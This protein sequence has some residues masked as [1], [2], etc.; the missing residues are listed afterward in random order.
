MVCYDFSNQKAKI[1][2][3]YNKFVIETMNNN[4]INTIDLSAEYVKVKNLLIE[5]DI[6]NEQLY[7]LDASM[8][9]I[10]NKRYGDDQS[11]CNVNI[12]CDLSLAGTFYGPE[13][14]IIEPASHGDNSGTVV[15]RGNLQVQGEHTFINSQTIEVSDNIIRMHANYNSLDFGGIEVV[16]DTG[17][18]RQFLWN[19]IEDRWILEDPLFLN[20]DLDVSNNVNISGDLVVDGNF[21]LSG[22][23]DVDND[24]SFNGN[25]D[26]SNHLTVEGDASFNG[27]V[28]ISGILKADNISLGEILKGLGRFLLI[29]A[30]GNIVD[31]SFISFDGSSVI[32]D[33]SAGLKIPAGTTDE[34]PVHALQGHI[35]YNNTLDSFEGYDGNNWGKLGGLKDV[36]GDTYISVETSAGNDNDDLDFYTAG[37]RYLQIDKGGNIL[38]GK[39]NNL[40]KFTISGETGDTKIAGTVEISGNEGGV[41]LIVHNDISTNNIYMNQFIYGNEIMYIDPVH[42]TADNSGLLVIRADVQILGTQTTINS[43]T[44]EVSHNIIVHIPAALTD[45]GLKVKDQNDHLRPFVFKNAPDFRWDLSDAIIFRDDA[46]FSNNVDIS[47]NLYVNGDVSFQRN[48]DVSGRLTT[49]TFTVLGDVSFN[50]NV[51]ISD[52]LVTYGDVSLISAVDISGKL[53]IFD[54]GTFLGNG[55]GLVVVNDASLNNDLYL[56]GTLYTGQNFIIDPKGHGDNTGL[57]IIKGGLQVDGSSTVINSTVLDISDHRILLSSNSTNQSQTDGAGIE[58]SNNKL[59]IY[60]YANDRWLT[61]IGLNVSGD[62]IVNEDTSLNN[63]VDISGKFNINGDSSFNK[64]VD[65]NNNFNVYSD[66]SFNGN[67]YIAQH[68]N[69]NDTLSVNEDASFNQNVIINETLEVDGIVTLNNN[70]DISENLYVNGDV[71]F[72]RNLDVSGTIRATTIKVLGDVSFDGFV[73]ISD[74]LVVYG[75]ASFNQDVDICGILHGND[76]IINGDAS[77]NQNVEISDQL[78]V[79]GDVS[80]NSFVDISDRLVVNGDASFNQDVDIC[81]ILH[82]NKL[83]I[84]GD[85]SFNNNVDISENLY[86]NGDVSFQRNLDVSGQ[87]IATTIKILGDVSFNVNVDVSDRLVVYGDVSLN[88]NVDVSDRLV[89]EGDVSLNENV[90]ISNQLNVNGDASFNSNVDISNR[91]NVD[92]IAFHGL[93][94]DLNV[95][96]NENS[97][98]VAGGTSTSK[99]A[100]SQD[101]GNNWTEIT[102]TSTLFTN[103]A[104]GAQS[105]EFNGSMWVAA[106]RGGNHVAYSYDGINW[107]SGGTVFSHNG[108]DIKYDN[109]RGRWI[110]VGQGNSSTI[111]YSYDGINWTTLAVN[112]IEQ[113]IMA[114]DLN[115][116]T[117]VV[118][119]ETTAGAPTLAHSYDLINWTTVGVNPFERGRCVLWTGERWLAGGVIGDRDYSIVYSEDGT[120]WNDIANADNLAQG[121]SNIFSTSC[122]KIATNGSTI[123]AVGQGTNTIAYS[124][125]GGLTFTGLGTSI[126]GSGFSVAWC[127]IQWVVGGNNSEMAVSRDGIVWTPVTSPFTSTTFDIAWNRSIYNSLVDINERL[128]TMETKI[129]VSYR[130]VDISLNL[131]V[132]GDASFNQNVDISGTLKVTD[133]QVLGDASFNNNVD[134]SENLY[135]N[136]DVF[137]QR[138]LDVSDNLYVNGDVSFQR[139]LDV[140]GKL[141]VT[142]LEVLGDVSFNGN[143]D[144]SNRLLV[145]GDVSFQSDVD[146]SK[147]L[148]V[149]GETILS[150]LRVNDLSNNRVVIVGPSG[151]LEDDGNF[152]FDG[153]NLVIDTSHA[154]QIPVGTTGERPDAVTGQIRFNVTDNRYEGYNG[155][156]WVP[157]GESG[158][159]LIVATGSGT[160][161]LN[162]SNDHGETWNPVTDSTTLF[163]QAEDVAWNGRRWVAVGEGPSNIAYSDDG[164]IWFDATNSSSLFSAQADAIGANNYLWV[165]GGSFQP[166]NIIYSSDGINW[167]Y[168]NNSPFGLTCNDVKYGGNLW[169]AA[170]GYGVTSPNYTLGYSYNGKDWYGGAGAEIFATQGRA[171]AWN[172]KLWVAVGG[173]VSTPFIIAYSYDGKN[174]N[175]VT[176]STSIIKEAYGIAWNGS[177]FVIVGESNTTLGITNTIL[178]SEDGINWTGRGTTVFG[179]GVTI[180]RARGITWTGSNWIAVGLNQGSPSNTIATSLDGITWVGKGS[181]NFTTRGTGVA[182]NNVFDYNKYQ[183]ETLDISYRNVD[184]SLN[185]LVEGRV[186]ISGYVSLNYNVDISENLYVNG[187]VSFQRNL[188]VS[189]TIRATTIKVLGDV[190]FDGFVDISDRLVVYGD[191]SFNQDVDICGIL[192]G[193]DLIINGDASF[194]QNVDISGQLIVKGDVSLNSNVDISENLYV[195]GDVSF[196]RN[197]DVSGQLT[198]T[199]L[200]V[201]GDVS[202]DGFV[203]ISNRLVAYSDASF[204]QDVDICGI[205]HGN[206][207]IINSD[208]SFNNNVTISNELIVNSDVSLNSNVDISENL[209]VNGDVSFQ[210]N[211]DV[212]GLLTVTTLKVLGDVSF[213]GNVDISDRL[214]AYGDASF[215]ED[216]DICGTLHGYKLIINDDAS[217]NSIVDIS[218]QLIVNGDVSLNSNVDISENLYVNGDVSFQRNLDVSGQIVATSLKVLGD[219]SFNRN[220]DISD[221]LVVYVDTSLNGN[222]DIS[223]RLV[224]YGDVSL[225]G[226]VDISDKLVVRGDASFNSN[227]NVSG[228]TIL[229]TLRVNDL[230]ET[231]IVFVGSSGELIDSSFLTFDGSNLIIDTSYSIQIPVGTTDERPNPAE[232]GQIRYNITDSTFEGYDGNNWGSLGGVKDVD[233]DTYIL[234]ES[235]PGAD[236]DELQFYSAG[237][238]Y[239][240]IDGYGNII[241]GSNM[242]TISGETGKT[243]IAGDVS[244][245]N[246]VDI[247]ENLYVNGDVSFQRNLDVSGQ[248]V[249]TSLKVLGDVSFNGNVD[250]SD[251]LV[252]NGDISL[253]GNVDISDRLVTNGDVSLNSS[254]DISNQLNVNGDASFNSSVDISDRLIVNDIAFEGLRKDLNVLTGENNLVI[255][256]GIDDVDDAN[257]IAYSHDLGI[258]WTSVTSSISIFSDVNAGGQSVE[259][260][261]SMWVAS[262]RGTNTIAYS[263]DGIIWN[264]AGQIFSHSGRVVKYDSNRGR[265]IVGGQG[266]P[267]TLV[268][269]YDGINWKGLGNSA[270]SLKVM[271]LDL[272]NTRYVACGEGTSAFAYSDD[273]ITW[274]TISPSPFELGRCVLWTGRRWFA[275]GS[276]GIANSSL[277]YSDDGETWIDVS[278]ANDLTQGSANVISGVVNGIAFNGSTIVIVGKGINTIAYSKDHGESFTGVGSSYITDEGFAIAWC[279]THWIAGGTRN[280]IL[281]STD[282]IIWTTVTAPIPISPYHISWN[283]SIYGTLGLIAEKLSTL[284]ERIDVSYRNVDISLHLLVEGDASFNGDVDISGILNG[285]KLVINDDASFN[286]KVDI[287]DNLYVNGDV[288]FQ[289]NLDVS[290]ILKTTDLVVLQDSS[291]HGFVDISEN[292]YVNGDVSFQRNLDVSGNLL[293]DGYSFDGVRSATEYLHNNENIIIGV[294][295]NTNTIGYSFDYGIT[296]NTVPGSADLIGGPSFNP[297]ATA[298]AYNGHRWIVIGNGINIALYSDDGL[299]WTGYNTTNPGVEG[300]FGVRG[301]CIKWNP[302]LGRFIAS[303][304]SSSGDLSNNNLAMTE[305]GSEWTPLGKPMGSKTEAFDFNPYGRYVYVGSGGTNSIA[306][307][308]D[309][310]TYNRLGN[311][312][313]SVGRKVLWIGGTRWVAV[314]MPGTCSIAVSDTNGETWYDV[315]NADDLTQGSS[316]IF[317]DGVALGWNGSRLLA[318]GDGSNRIAYSDDLGLTWKIV[319][320]PETIFTSQINC[321]VW[322]GVRWL[323]GGAT[324]NRLAYS[325]DNGLTWTA[326]ENAS[327]T[328]S[329]QVMDIAWNNNFNSALANAAT[330]IYTSIDVSYRNVDISLNLLVEGRVDISG[331]VSL[332]YN[333][334]ISNKLNVFGDTSLNENVDITKKLTVG[335]TT[336]L[337][338]ATTIESTLDVNDTATFIGSGKGVII[339]NDLS[340]NNHIYMGSH[341]YGPPTLYIDPVH[342]TAEN[343]GLLVIKADLQVLGTQT[344]VNSETTEVS[345]NIIVHLPPA[346]NSGGF[347][348][349]DE[350][351][352][353]H[354]LIWKNSPDFKWELTSP[355]VFTDDASFNEDVDIYGT[356]HL[357]DMIVN[358]DVSFN[359]NV[360]ISENLYVNGD[361]SFQRN[362]DVSGLIRTN[363]VSCDDFNATR[364]KAEINRIAIGVNSGVT[365]QGTDSIGIG[366]L[367]G[368]NTQGNYAIS[369]GSN[370]GQIFQGNN[371]VAIG[372]FAGE[373]NQEKNS[374]AIGRLAGRTNQYSES[375]AIGYDAGGIDQS[376]NSIA[377][378][379]QAGN[380]NQGINAIA[381]GRRA[382]LTNQGTNA[383]AIGAIANT[384][385]QKENTIIISAVGS[386]NATD[387]SNALYINPIRN[388]DN[389]YLL[390]YNTL[391]KEITHS[392]TLDIDKLKVLDISC[393][394]IDVSGRLLVEGDASFNLGVTVGQ[395]LGVGFENSTLTDFPDSNYRIHLNAE[396]GS[397]HG[398]RVSCRNTDTEILR[399]DGTSSTSY[400]G[401]LRFLGSGTGNNNSF[402]ITMNNQNG[403]DVDAI[404]I[405]QDGNI[406]IRIAE[407]TSVL[408]VNG[409]A[410]FNNNVDISENLYVNG[411]VSFQRNLDVSGQLIATSLKIL[412]DVSFNGYVDISENLYVNGDVSFQRNLDVSGRLLVDGN[413][414]AGL[415]QDLN[416][417]NNQDNIIVALG[418]VGSGTI[419]YSFDF[420]ETW[421]I[422]PGSDSIFSLWAFSLDYNGSIWVA[423][424]RG[425]NTIAYSYDGINWN[426]GGTPFS[427]SGRK[428]KYNSYLGYWVAGGQGGEDIEFSYD[429]INWTPHPGANIDGVTSIRGYDFN[430]TRHVIVTTSPTDTTYSILYSDDLINWTGITDSKTL[431][432]RDGRHV[433]WTGRRWIVGGSKQTGTATMIYS[434]DAVSWFDV[435]NASNLTQGSGNIFSTTCNKLAY[436]G[437]MI[438]AVGNGT[439][440][441]AY[442]S[443]HGLS[444]TGISITGF[445]T[446]FAVEWCGTRWVVGGDSLQMLL[447]N[448]GINWT[449]VVNPPFNSICYE[450]KWNRSVYGTFVNISENITELQNTVDISYRNVDISL[451]LLVEGDTSLNGNVDISE[452]LYVN[453]DVSFQRNLDVS[454]KLFATTF[455]AID[456]SFRNVDISN[457]LFVE[458]DSSFNNFVDISNLRVGH[459]Y[460]KTDG[461]ASSSLSSASQTILG[462]L[463]VGYIGYDD[464]AGIRHNNLNST[465]QYALIQNNA[466]TT[467]LNAANGQN[468]NFNIG[469]SVKMR[470][471][472]DGNF[473]IGELNPDSILE[474]VGDSSFNGKVDI[475]DKFNVNGDTSFNNNVD[476]SENLYV[477][478]DVSFQRNL[479]VSGKLF[480]TTFEAMDVSFRNVDISNRL[481]VEGDASFN[482][483]TSFY[484][485]VE[486]SNLLI[487]A[488]TDA[489]GWAGVKHK[490]IISGVGYALLQKDDGRTIINSLSPQNIEFRTSAVLMGIF[491]DRKFGLGTNNPTS[492][493]TVVGDSSL[494]GFV[495]ISENLYVNGDVSFQRNLDVSGQLTATSL[496]VL[497]DVS[498]N[499][500]VDIS[501][502]LYVNGDVSFQ[503]AVDVSGLFTG[504]DVSCDDFRATRIKAVSNGAI[505][506]GPLA[507]STSQGIA[508]IAIG[509]SAGQSSADNA[510]SIG[511]QAGETSQALRAIAIGASAGN[512][513]QSNSAIAIG[514]N[515]GKTSQGINSIAIGQLA[516]EISQGE[517]SVAIGYLAGRRNPL[518]TEKTITINATGSTLPC[519]ISS[520]FFVKPIRNSDNSYILQYNTSSGEITYSNN[521]AELIGLNDLSDVI[522]NMTT[523]SLKI[524]DTSKVSLSNAFY[525]TFTGFTSGNEILTGERNSGYGYQS[526]FN[527]TQGDFN[528]GYGA[529]SLMNLTEAVSNTAVGHNALSG[530]SGGMTGSY[531]T[532]IGKNSMPVTTTGNSNVAVGIKS[533]FRNSDGSNN[534]VIGGNCMPNNT[535]GSYNIGIGTN[536]GRTTT[537]GKYNIFIGFDTVGSA[538]SNSNEIVIGSQSDGITSNRNRGHGSNTTTLGNPQITNTIIYGL[539]EISNLLVEGDASFNKAVHMNGDVSLNSNV[540]ISGKLNVYADSS[541]NQSV[542]ISNHLVVSGTRFSSVKHTRDVVDSNTNFMVAVG[543]GGSES[544]NKIAYSYDGITWTGV[545]DS[546]SI[547]TNFAQSVATNGTTWVAVG[548][549]GNAYAYSYDGITWTGL[550][551]IIGSFNI[552]RGFSV[553]WINE[554]GK[555]FMGVHGGTQ[556]AYS[557]DGINWNWL[558]SSNPLGSKMTDFDYNHSKSR[559]VAVG[560][561]SDT[562]AYSDDGITWTGLGNTI[563]SRGVGVT[564]N[565]KIWVATGQKDSL[566][567]TIV[568]SEDNGVTWL[569]ASNASNL[570]QGS[571]TIFTT[572]ANQAAWN[573]EMWVVVGGGTNSIAYSNDGKIWMPLGNTIFSEGKGVSWTGTKWVG[574][575]S[576]NRIAYSYDGI[577]WIG[578]LN[579]VNIFSSYG[580]RLAWKKNVYPCISH[581]S[582]RIN[583]LSAV[584]TGGTYAAQ[585]DFED[586]SQTVL[587]LSTNYY[588]FKSDFIDVSNRVQDLS[589]NLLKRYEDASF[590]TVEIRDNLILTDLSLTNLDVSNKLKVAINQDNSGVI[591]KLQIGHIGYNGWA[592]IKNVNL[593]ENNQYAL[594]QS[595]SG[596][597]FLNA[598]ANEDL[599]LRLDNTDYFILDTAQTTIGR[600]SVTNYNVKL[601]A[602]VSMVTNASVE[603]DFSVN[604][605]ES[606]LVPKIDNT[607]SLG[608]ITNEW[609]DLFVGGGSIYMDKCKI[610]HRLS[611]NNTLVI[612]NSGLALDISHIS[613][614]NFRPNV[615]FNGNVEISGLLITEGINILDISFRNVDISNRLFVE[616]DSSFNNFVDISNLTV[617][618]N[619][620]HSTTFLGKAA[621]GFIGHNDT[622]INHALFSH[623]DYYHLNNSYALKQNNDGTTH[624]NAATGTHITFRI[625]NTAKMRLLTNGDFGIGTTTPEARL[626]IVGGGLISEEDSSFNKNLMISGE[627]INS[628]GYGGLSGEILTSTGSG[629]KWNTMMLN[630]LSDVIVDITDFS[631]SIKIGSNKTG[632]LNNAYGN[633]LI[634]WKSGDSITTGFNNTG[635]GFHTLNNAQGGDANTAIGSGALENVISGNANTSIGNSSLNLLTNGDYNTSIGSGSLSDTLTGSNNIALGRKAGEI[636]TTGSNNIFIGYQAIPDISEGTNQIVIGYDIS[637]KGSNTVLLGNN[638]TTDTYLKGRVDMTDI[639][640]AVVVHD[641]TTVNDSSTKIATAGSIRKYIKEATPIYNSSKI[642][643]DDKLNNKVALS[644]PRDNRV[645]IRENEVYADLDNKTAGAQEFTFGE[646]TNDFYVAVGR[647][648]TNKILYSYD[649]YKW[650]AG[651]NASNIFSVRGYCVEYDGLKYI[652]VG[653]SSSHTMAVSIDGITW[654]GRNKPLNID[655]GLVIKYENGIWIYGGE[656]TGGD[657]MAYSFE[658]T[659]WHHCYTSA[660][661]AISTIFDKMC[662]GL[663]YN[664]LVWVASG[665][666]DSATHSLAYSE[667]GIRWTGLGNSVFSTQGNAVAS[668]GEVFLAGGQGA[669]V[670]A[671]STNGI[672]WTPITV[673]INLKV[674]AIACNGKIWVVG[675]N[676]GSFLAYSTDNGY[677]FTNI[678]QNIITSFVNGLYWSGRYFFASGEG[679]NALAISKDGINWKKLSDHSFDEKGG[680]IVCNNRKR[681][682]IK[683]EKRMSVVC[684]HGTN[685]LAYETLTYDISNMGLTY[686]DVSGSTDIF[687]SGAYA[688]AHDGKMWVAAG[689]GSNYSLAYSDN[690]TVWH[691]IPHSKD[692]LFTDGAEGIAYNGKMWVATGNNYASADMSNIV[693]AYSTDGLCWVPVKSSTRIMTKGFCVEWGEDIW[694]VGGHKTLDGNFTGLSTMAYSYNGIDWKMVNGPQIITNVQ[695][696]KW[697]GEIFVAVGNAS[698][699]IAWSSNGTNWI[700]LGTGIFSAAGRGIEYSKKLKIWVAV[701]SGT[702]TIAYSTDAISWTGIGTSIFSTAGFGV[703]YNGERF[704]AYGKGTNSI[705][706]SDDGINWTGLGTSLFTTQGRNGALSNQYGKCTIVNPVVAVGEDGTPSQSTIAYS[707]D[708]FNWAITGKQLFLTNGWFVAYNGIMWVGVGQGGNSWRPDTIAY[709]YD[710]LNWVGLGRT[711]FTTRG[712]TVAWNGSYWIA[713]GRGTNQ[714]AISYDGITWTPVNQPFTTEC[715]SVCWTGEKWIALGSGTHKVATS[716]DGLNWTGRGNYFVF[717]AGVHAVATNG[718]ITVGTGANG[719]MAY[720]FNGENWTNIASTP[721]SNHVYG[722]ATNGKMWVAGGRGTNTLAYSYDGIT[723]TGAG[724]PIS[725]RAYGIAWNG[726]YWIAVGRGNPCAVISYDGINWLPVEDSNNVPFTTQGLAISSLSKPIGHDGLKNEFVLN[727]YGPVLSNIMIVTGPSYYADYETD[728]YSTFNINVKGVKDQVQN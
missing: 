220:V 404:V 437:S 143:V 432:F 688:V 10:F 698:N 536:A 482:S 391:T 319:S 120:S 442:S 433:L 506:I 690:G 654:N 114:L 254:V 642:Q 121:S 82:G 674:S 107:N 180:G 648:T 505:A 245:N 450:I 685:S 306:Y 434:D 287:S 636:N 78:N 725:S 44:T 395:N 473:G 26:I 487:G 704:I 475:S 75:D 5:G 41:G 598:E 626:H 579:S 70:V 550:G 580:A 339:E 217:F 362:L 139:N 641:L 313:F 309:F 138:N 357:N 457:R 149:S 571:A 480:S 157:L 110:L 91:L 499:G 116:S 18:I 587:D 381:I 260:N 370:A 694:L 604:R 132:E 328:F 405:P 560:E 635:L 514:V 691:G 408:H 349:K 259:Y 420:G 503:R 502:N 93:R 285:N 304:H 508:T 584:L 21:D 353:L 444:F 521:M 371:S 613:H 677:T 57:V 16:D 673:G 36:D 206:K 458:G 441:I 153:S 402:A 240:T 293:V 179:T 721:F 249:A 655:K 397:I 657:T 167:H 498:F 640:G 483:H 513:S 393:R 225:N 257:T 425:G 223:N 94:Q 615:S 398:M 527:L 168:A 176:G 722:I 81:G 86:V 409:D 35:R 364:I 377:I 327:H 152:T 297:G 188:D 727:K 684:G 389:S 501:E 471:N 71:S 154:I 495:D 4:P 165:A 302:Q 388:V 300:P 455:E 282:G 278:N 119:G 90:D 208:A 692:Q 378:G 533:L 658:G 156:A 448:D 680:N 491:K 572:R 291:F 675:G 651:P 230:T 15:I 131:L 326:V 390:Q 226:N 127:G 134:I 485:Y 415:R 221:R 160:N 209:Y 665:R 603:G 586:L 252:V 683:F 678:T 650:L 295:G 59:F 359:G 500:F 447:S 351:D 481:L 83:I 700:G 323:A 42:P 172:G 191:A 183:L 128:N 69:I 532:A 522:F 663:A 136:G 708:G 87:L 440:S 534:T 461:T 662:N 526:L 73:D 307:S 630:D 49:T 438:V 292:L 305:D 413:S 449:Q 288:S 203:D 337:R 151:K 696:I 530:S 421:T 490:D 135:V 170:G 228:E 241:V 561:G 133:L 520:A 29:D 7:E 274:T 142:T 207:L 496:R 564:S 446:G 593:T 695:G 462:N 724:S 198:V 80:L 303:G 34:R 62:L 625:S 718:L 345:S 98:I 372:R 537:T 235:S 581:L 567:S 322:C 148:T 23:I 612:D 539:I 600:L 365:S 614:V 56:G 187:D 596:K 713:G 552:N 703:H 726:R 140:S 247:S 312:I 344:T 591:G 478:G 628:A 24:A 31:S 426:A 103:A 578:V 566:T 489:Q 314:G 618:A 233:G 113:K 574:L 64:P 19:N 246:N 256:V 289:R 531:N 335:G 728:G 582:S 352:N 97:L 466:G 686:T 430:E 186:D 410:S 201:L 369:L 624:L 375:I 608:S 38:I 102:A 271:G 606:N 202:F 682:Q 528:T 33:T 332:N 123:I 200:K 411:D 627:I 469:N 50:G 653:Q 707:I 47:E 161:T 551:S 173:G 607:Y 280:E 159:N 265:W 436:N 117:Y 284:E 519:D 643:T 178:T 617:G 474:V 95:L 2:L 195:N 553:K 270:I 85:A 340:V 666:H 14:L 355:I 277:V 382:G 632:T 611:S 538:N 621:I 517:N 104:S 479:D 347:K 224:V 111:A 671:R 96:N 317:T 445:T 595:S 242:F 668:N 51:D 272:N 28:D 211:L 667:D 299:N 356:L 194:N 100:Y 74:R 418:D 523:Q 137:F 639:C 463:Q 84:N 99:I 175:G 711:I 269:S 231:R 17:V 568:Y 298:I 697:N 276:K 710:G 320:G 664:G 535:T 544:N 599:R 620:T 656:D 548:N 145:Y 20:D 507:G 577:N 65:I 670:L 417:L 316:S 92:G 602:D 342:P 171:I 227:V 541:F 556:F 669:N 494:N 451:N 343:S 453:G 112:P 542:D 181:T 124:K 509:T 631:N 37:V 60:D 464:W 358:G 290:G 510:I 504:A 232:Q 407:P 218:E 45:G 633:T 488:I 435:T 716:T 545:S 705:A 416:V 266:S 54:T 511:I 77:F 196:Q 385:D 424:G 366:N 333:V 341:L 516:G 467:I 601:N 129:D 184:I 13:T 460:G 549:G 714:I 406:G 334:D 251:R 573:G 459:G 141:V 283:K 30:S 63:A 261:G 53:N 380:T 338:S 215:N 243:L 205:L 429:G 12:N 55:N 169:V 101:F 619:K 9:Q 399:F 645:V 412:D 61:N 27:D 565:D 248:I 400:G 583:D 649:G 310:T 472:S 701:G 452:N 253:N 204:N 144:I 540:D 386:H 638:D 477:N 234:A 118:C 213:N 497:G 8:I 244:M 543:G 1:Y 723:W 715:K 470:L 659:T 401:A 267:D 197:L 529:G 348:V 525:N 115:E 515:S 428:I 486:A 216:V 315:S 712:L 419:A 652:A 396:D 150:T 570:S 687:D 108:R 321:L 394:H 301:W 427:H 379:N 661:G 547:F 609:K 3:S 190:S 558:A 324:P 32:I 476:I 637:G 439:N 559:F 88:G 622:N 22:R 76:L 562:I 311:S 590:G 681:N 258:T 193:N 237:N 646:S 423:G 158:N 660:G 294:G 162:W 255:G 454:G 268:Y 709:S 67:V 262:G 238:K 634:G 336:I 676:A 594:I 163:N 557:Y 443:D 387:F 192:H 383:I 373:T 214:V 174:W 6:S 275:G 39:G 281:K 368:Q 360:D 296:W 66:S 554:L 308:D 279:G 68:L 706:Y 286:S 376:S 367:A 720:T 422:V 199:T 361:V 79:N 105:V 403:T 25:V 40:S 354:G 610:M 363:D 623:K 589:E 493:L 130:N 431:F 563:L 166:N 350:N 484:N 109:Y 555:Y 719:K 48:L 263:E 239:M 392:R 11:F 177:L 592:G 575:G 146:I 46:S 699:T 597:T 384:T 185:L 126:I 644:F 264:G 576:N 518:T 374:I 524:G 702:N 72:Q 331:D 647:G 125:D 588:V 546:T 605:I 585:A 106:G 689:I 89:V 155:N 329:S 717:D 465:A 318:G 273:L 210:R 182:I 212:S 468:I 147:N 229:S 189:G 672:N 58:V 250:V 236:N 414:F 679:T 512:T 456:V 222:V 629:W 122:V 219:V 330:K 43:T 52:R 569:D 492:L 693:T 164:I 325:D 616:G 346:L